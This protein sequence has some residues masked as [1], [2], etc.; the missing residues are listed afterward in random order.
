MA[1]IVNC[2]ADFVK[3]GEHAIISTE[4][5]QMGAHLDG[6]E[7]NVKVVRVNT[8]LRMHHHLLIFTIWVKYNNED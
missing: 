6:L 3:M 2:H 5:V 1:K 8:I 4:V 7:K